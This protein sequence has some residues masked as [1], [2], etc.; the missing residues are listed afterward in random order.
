MFDD[1]VVSEL[2]AGRLIRYMLLYICIERARERESDGIWVST[3]SNMFSMMIEK[4]ILLE[5]MGPVF[6]HT[7]SLYI[8]MYINI[9]LRRGIDG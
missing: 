7:L 2:L 4:R 1:Q 8:Y 9:I 3:T 5:K 6:R